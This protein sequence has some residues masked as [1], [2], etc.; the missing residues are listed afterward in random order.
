MV[1]YKSGSLANLG[2]AYAQTTN[3]VLLVEI[4]ARVWIFYSVQ[5]FYL[6]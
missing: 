2:M 6:K 1:F 3:A 4:V 5:H